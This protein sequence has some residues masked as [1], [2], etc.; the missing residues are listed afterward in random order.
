MSWLCPGAEEAVGVLASA[1]GLEALASAFDG[2]SNWAQ[3]SSFWQLH[4][5]PKGAQPKPVFMQS[6]EI[7]QDPAQS[8]TQ[9]SENS[10]SL[11]PEEGNSDI[12]TVP[13]ALA[14]CLPAPRSRP[15][16]TQL[17]WARSL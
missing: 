7:T 8:E 1:P 13:W 12:Q 4:P 6:A 9:G 17:S 15:F 2:A 10:H 11:K 14:D 16:S 5:H 3:L